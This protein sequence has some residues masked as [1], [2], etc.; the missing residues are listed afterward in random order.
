MIDVNMLSR[1]ADQLE[2]EA[3][4]SAAA[5]MAI[6]RALRRQGSPAPYTTDKHAA[7]LLAPPGHEVEVLTVMGR[8]LGS[9]WRPARPTETG[10]AATQELALCAAIMR[11]WVVRLKM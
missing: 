1:I 9:C 11:A 2:L 5:D 4:G 3:R 10:Q 7:K 6:H 8:N